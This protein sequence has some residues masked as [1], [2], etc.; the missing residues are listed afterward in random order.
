MNSEQMYCVEASCGCITH[1][2][3]GRLRQCGVF[4]AQSTHGKLIKMDA[5]LSRHNNAFIVRKYPVASIL[6]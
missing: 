1:P 5:D 2:L 4:G 6:P 3:A